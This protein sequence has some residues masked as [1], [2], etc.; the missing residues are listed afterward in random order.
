[1][2]RYQLDP[3]NLP[4]LTKSDLARIDRM[5]DEDIDYSDIPELDNGFFTKEAVI[6]DMKKTY[7]FEET[8]SSPEEGDATD[9]ARYSPENKPTAEDEL[10]FIIFKLVRQDCGYK[11]DFLDSWATSAYER[12]ILALEQA[13]FVELQHGGRIYAKLLPKWHKFEEWMELHDRRK[14]I[15]EARHELATV[16]GFK[17]ETIAFIYNITL[18]ELTGEE[19]EKDGEKS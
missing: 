3:K 19:E 6:T 12:A 2:Q 14:R 4:Q 1:M 7:P 8:E 9:F 11:E 10:W 16:P 13:G 17:P 15:R 5:K 18:A